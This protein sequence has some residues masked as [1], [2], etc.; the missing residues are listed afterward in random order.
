RGF[1]GHIGIQAVRIADELGIAATDAARSLLDLYSASL[2]LARRLVPHMAIVELDVHLI[3]D[4]EAIGERNV[5]RGRPAFSET[6]W[7]QLRASRALNDALLGH[8]AISGIAT[9]TLDT[10][11]VSIE[12]AGD[13]VLGHVAR[14]VAKRQVRE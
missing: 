4:E 10:T 13:D 12:E 8:R 5:A 6:D 1:P 9:T 3:A 14:L 7:R 2:G 11:R